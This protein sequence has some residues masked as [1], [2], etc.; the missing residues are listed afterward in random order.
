MYR[1]FRKK[2]IDI[3]LICFVMLD[4]ATTYIGVYVLRLSELN[5]TVRQFLN[6]GYPQGYITYA[7]IY[8]IILIFSLVLKHC[9]IYPIRDI[10]EIM[11]FAWLIILA[12]SII[13]NV[14]F[15]LMKVM[16]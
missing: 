12:A 10:F 2:I 14:N 4:L 15:I 8:E 13:L 5:P 3:L 11:V 7:F 6:L 9:K 16:S 1:V